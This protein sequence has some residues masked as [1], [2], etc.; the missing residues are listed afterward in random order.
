MQG[1]ARRKRGEEVFTRNYDRRRVVVRDDGETWP[2]MSEAAR[3]HGVHPRSMQRAC[4]T[5]G[6]LLRARFQAKGG[7]GMD[8]KE[9]DEKNLAKHKER[10]GMIEQLAIAE[11]ENR[12]LGIRADKLEQQLE[13]ETRK[14]E[15]RMRH[16]DLMGAALTERRNQLH[17][18]GER[19]AELEKQVADL[20]AELAD[21][22][23]MLRESDQLSERERQ[24]LDMWPKFEDEELVWFGDGYASEDGSDYD[25]CQIEFDDGYFTL[26][27]DWEVRETFLT[28][29]RVKRPAPKVL[30]ADGV[31]IK[32]GDTVWHHSGFAHGV[33]TSIDAGS[34]MGTVRYVN[35]GVEFRDAAKDLTHT[36]RDSW[37]RLE[38]DAVKGVCE[39]AGAE[40]KP[41][42]I[43]AHTCCGCRFDEDGD[44]PT[45]EKQM[46]LDI[47]RRAK[48]LAGVEVGE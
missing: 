33:V 34:L 11:E 5:G 14:A 1:H 10:C 29:E 3:A 47:I 4:H 7:L 9:F 28:G 46:A 18:R 24:I 27:D 17:E 39:Y 41:G 32:V 26:A 2:N 37:E 42:T 20:R 48:A 38:E 43:D 25:A 6:H 22:N 8:T 45:C 13:S 21:T 12:K 30:D 15:R 40:R 16:I 35:G 19:I 23:R 31:E 44:G 36:R